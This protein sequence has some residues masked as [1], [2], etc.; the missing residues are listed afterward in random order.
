MDTVTFDTWHF[1]IAMTI[2]VPGLAGVLTL[3]WKT[4]ARQD[5]DIAV[6]KVQLE[7]LMGYKAEIHELK[8]T[9]TKLLI[10]VR[11]IREFLRA[12]GIDNGG[13]KHKD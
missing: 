4:N 11:G 1:F 8:E 12:R 10:E 2:L 9:T 13:P 5:K 6:M 7:S 3:F